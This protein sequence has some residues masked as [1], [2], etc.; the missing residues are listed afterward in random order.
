ML[1]ASKIKAD[2]EEQGRAGYLVL[3]NDVLDPVDC[4]NKVES[5]YNNLPPSCTDSDVILDFT[6]M[7]VIASVGSVL[8]CLDERRSI[9]YTPGVFNN[10]L[11]AVQ[12]RDPVEI[13]LDWN[14]L[15]FPNTATG[16]EATLP[17]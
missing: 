8:A 7:T 10:E 6:G 2:L 4:R 17:S 14:M 13:S 11:K 5:I 9:Q 12:P 3:I 15:R 1:L 16:N